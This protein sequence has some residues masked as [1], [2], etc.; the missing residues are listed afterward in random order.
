MTS[1]V[2]RDIDPQTFALWGRT[3]PTKFGAP[4]RMKYFVLHLTVCV[5]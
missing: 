5:C 2:G 3:A 4:L 1:V